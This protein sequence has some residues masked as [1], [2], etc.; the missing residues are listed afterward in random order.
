MFYTEK[1]G[2]VEEHSHWAKEMVDST[3]IQSRPI[4]FRVPCY[5]TVQVKFISNSGPR[6]PGTISPSKFGRTDFHVFSKTYI[7]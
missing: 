1:G 2:G 4:T 5:P 6:K 7:D 3:A